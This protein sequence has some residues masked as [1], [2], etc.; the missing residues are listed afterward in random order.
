[1]AGDPGLLAMEQTMGYVKNLQVTSA[2]MNLGWITS[3]QDTTQ[4]HKV[5]LQVLIP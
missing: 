2:M 3:G 1:L 5:G 4:A